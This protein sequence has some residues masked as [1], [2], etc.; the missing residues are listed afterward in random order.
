MYYSS[1]LESSMHFEVRKVWGL[2]NVPNTMTNKIGGEAQPVSG[3]RMLHF[4]KTI[5]D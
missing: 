1:Q 5:G 3:L 2:E 4:T